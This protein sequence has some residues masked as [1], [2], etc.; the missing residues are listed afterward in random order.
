MNQTDLRLTQAA[1]TLG[2]L[3]DEALVDFALRNLLSAD[4]TP[5]LVLLAGLCG[6]ERAEASA[7]FQRFLVSLG[8]PAMDRGDALT[9]Y[10]QQVAA[11]IVG[12]TRDAY[13]GARDI[14]AVVVTRGVQTHAFDGLIYAASEY[15]ERP[16]DRAHFAAEI[17]EEARRIIAQ[18]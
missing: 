11:Q 2:I 15:E 7:L 6:S 3:S 8:A 9:T 1:W 16:R 10:V 17:I 14:A 5:E 13:D 4:A 12:R 18:P